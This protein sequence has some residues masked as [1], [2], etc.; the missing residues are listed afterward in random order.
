MSQALPN[1]DFLKNP[2]SKRD[3]LV[4]AFQFFNETSAQ[5]EESYRGLEQRIKQLSDELDTARTERKDVETKNDALESQMRALLNFL[6]GGVIVLDE[7]GVVVEA[8][9]AAK[10]L[11]DYQHMVGKLWR[12]LIREC[13]APK[14]DD[15]LE[16]S[17]KS[18][19]RI[20]ISTGS[21]NQQGQIILLTDQTET[22]QLQENL[23]RHE[24]LTALG[25]MVSILAHQIRT[26]LTAA[27]LYAGNLCNENLDTGKQREF[28]KKVL[29]RLQHMEKQVRDMLFFVKN[30]LPLNDI[31]TLGDLELGLRQAAE[32]SISL[33]NAKCHWKN[34]CTAEKIKCNR[35]AL[36]SAVMNLINNAIQA[37]EGSPV[38]SITMSKI[39]KTKSESFIRIKIE[40]NGS[41]MSEAQ[42]DNAMKMFITSKSHGNGIGL[43]VVQSVARAHGGQ[44]D[45]KSIVDKGTKAWIDLPLVKSNSF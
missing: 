22:R 17:T 43:C 44:F 24:K 8:N 14:N 39:R 20:S 10:S 18:G 13:F 28:S 45:L 27:I 12:T 6:P 7:N 36:I 42:I 2:Q 41:G 9:P 33:S 38:I 4:E 16:V 26:P 19:R 37:C 35:E 11:L 34:T 29:G 21:F 15:G 40:D 1:Y 5:L 23:S 32:C 30:E 25:K 31:I 3:S